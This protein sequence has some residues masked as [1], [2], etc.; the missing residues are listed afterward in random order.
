MSQ[1]LQVN[2]P[3]CSARLSIQRPSVERASITCVKCSHAF[4]IK[5]PQSSP[6]TPA[7]PPGPALG[8]LTNLDLPAAPLQPTSQQPPASFATA[9]MQTVKRRGPAK[10][11]Q[12]LKPILLAASAA[13]ALVLLSGGAWV[14]FQN[15]GGKMLGGVLP[16]TV[17]D[18]A[19]AVLS[20][21][22]A[23]DEALIR[24]AGEL[25][26]GNVVEIRDEFVATLEASRK[27][28]FRSVC[29]SPMSPSETD[30]LFSE[31]GLDEG[32]LDSDAKETIVDQ[33]QDLPDG[34]DKAVIRLAV[35]Q[36]STNTKFVREYLEHGHLELPAANTAGE[37]IARER[38]EIIRKFNRLLADRV[39]KGEAKWK[40]AMEKEKAKAGGELPEGPPPEK[41]QQEI[42]EDIDEIFGPIADDVQGFADRMT[43]L[44][45][46]RYKLEEADVGDE[47]QFEELFFYSMLA[48]G[49]V[50]NRLAL[51]RGDESKFVEA[52]KNLTISIQDHERAVRGT[53][54][55]KI[56]ALEREKEAADQRERERLAKIAEDKRQQ[57]NRVRAEKEAEEERKRQMAMAES[58]KDSA[59]PDSLAMDGSS[60]NG[61]GDRGMGAPFGGGNRFGGPFGPG[62]SR[63]G[64]RGPGSFRGGSRG[65]PRGSGSSGPPPIDTKTGFTIKM[66]NANGV[67]SQEITKK[68]LELKAAVSVRNSGGELT[69]KGGYTGPLAD[70]AKLID[71]GKVVSTDESTRTI[72]VEKE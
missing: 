65:G 39:E 16:G 34:P 46:Q 53:A 28:V 31:D 70:V 51:A 6:P 59:P 68:L 13:V 26:S 2:C 38:I 23:S 20:D 43:T 48:N 17:F 9:P 45:E 57:D 33:V 50:F 5:V 58:A 29:I 63:F 3:K 32:P 56:A 44:A 64:D 37:K 14:F 66:K 25:K 47:K 1:M 69:V 8:D 12:N 42:A 61:A 71:F 24:L 40:A 62:G 19:D 11:K 36:A 35:T 54:P 60:G 30:K 10:Q 22:E 72:V 15:G 55:S 4:V 27:L 7:A 67:S 49:R 21:A 52:F 18:S 41:T